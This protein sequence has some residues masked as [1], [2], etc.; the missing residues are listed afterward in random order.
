MRGGEPSHGQR[1][2]KKL[3]VYLDTNI[4]S[5]YEYGGDVSILARVTQ[6]DSSSQVGAGCHAVSGRSTGEW[7][8]GIKAAFSSTVLAA[9]LWLKESK[10]RRNTKCAAKLGLSLD[11]ATSMAGRSQRHKSP[12]ATER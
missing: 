8:G 6:V 4:I 5:A 3:T 10:P 11:K 12:A 7:G 9:R 2:T 1:A